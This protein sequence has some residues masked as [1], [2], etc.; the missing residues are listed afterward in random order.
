M[1]SNWS[2]AYSSELGQINDGDTFRVVLDRKMDEDG[3]FSAI[4]V[5]TLSF[6][7]FF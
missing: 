7:L 5:S 6:Y 2:P 3:K 1:M 4:L